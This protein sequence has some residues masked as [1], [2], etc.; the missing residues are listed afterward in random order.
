M[1]NRLQT[2][3]GTIPS[4]PS[5]FADDIQQLFGDDFDPDPLFLEES[6]ALG[7]PAATE[8]LHHRRQNLAD[9]EHQSRAFSELNNLGSLFLIEGHD[10]AAE[11][12]F[13]DRADMIASRYASAGTQRLVPTTAE[14][15]R[16]IQ[17]SCS[18][19]DWAPHDRITHGWIP[20]G[21]MPPGAH[22]GRI[23]HRRRSPSPN[24]GTT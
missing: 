17:Q 20:E 24:R 2:H 16:D 11:S 15:T 7:I 21:W 9:R 18:P 13:A 5:R 12:L 10:R 1:A 8:N 19:T 22:R 3:I 23:R 14:P 6:W 4:Q